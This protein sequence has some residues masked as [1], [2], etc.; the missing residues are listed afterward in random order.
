MKEEKVFFKFPVVVEF[1]FKPCDYGNPEEIVKHMCKSV[2]IVYPVLENER[3][4]RDFLEIIDIL[5]DFIS[6]ITFSN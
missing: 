1:S 2:G 5:K 4:A 6:S 3:E